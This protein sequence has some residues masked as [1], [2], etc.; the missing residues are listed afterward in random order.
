MIHPRK[1]RSFLQMKLLK[2]KK[3][4][5]FLPLLFI[6]IFCSHIPFDSSVVLSEDRVSTCNIFKFLLRLTDIIG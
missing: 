2:D 4:S 6:C 5:W 1:Y 3:G